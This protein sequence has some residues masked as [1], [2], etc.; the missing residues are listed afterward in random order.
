MNKLLQNLFL[1][2]L[3]SLTLSGCGSD[4]NKKYEGFMMP[5]SVAEGPDG[6]IYVSE[7]GERDIDKDGKISK[8]NRDGTIETIASGLYDPKG[9]VFLK[10]EKVIAIRPEMIVRL[11]HPNKTRVT[12]IDIPKIALLT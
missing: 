10:P 8:I 9:I 1:I 6:S 12:T 3:V 5:E 4:L 7:I 11:N 2:I